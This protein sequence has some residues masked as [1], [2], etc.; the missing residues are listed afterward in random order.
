MKKKAKY[1]L[2][3][4]KEYNRSLVN[5][6]SL[7]FWIFEELFANWIEAEKTGERGASP[8]YSEA[9]ILAMASL[10]FVFQQGGRHTGGLAASIFRL[11]KVALAVPDDRTLSRRMAG[12]EGQVANQTE[13]ET[14]SFGDR[15][16]GFESLWRRRMESPH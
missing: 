2:R 12:M 16:N 7:S 15:F 13:R 8:R 6:G 5:R 3:N 11:L 4:W 1:R 9:A 10:K 14:T